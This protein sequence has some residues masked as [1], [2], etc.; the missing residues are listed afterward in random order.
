MMPSIS[1]N[2]LFVFPAK[3]DLDQM[4]LILISSRFLS[5]F[6]PIRASLSFSDSFCGLG[7]SEGLLLAGTAILEADFDHFIFGL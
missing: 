1:V 4:E 6:Q 2:C 3:P 7:K 5:E